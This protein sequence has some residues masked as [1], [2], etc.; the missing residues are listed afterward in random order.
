LKN[1]LY[2]LYIYK[3]S[4]ED[5]TTTAAKPE[6]YTGNNVLGGAKRKNGHKSM[7]GC[8]ICENIKNKAKRGGYK[9]EARSKIAG[10]SKKKNGHSDTCTCP[11]CKNMKNAKKNKR[12]GY[13]NDNPPDGSDSDGDTDDEDSDSD[14]DTDAEIDDV[15]AQEN[16]QS[17]PINRGGRKSRKSRKGNGHK[18]GC[19]CPICKNM[20]KKS[21]RGGMDSADMAEKEARRTIGGRKT[22]KV[23]RKTT[24]RPKKRTHKRR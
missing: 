16:Q 9:K 18:P 17:A 23:K 13:N 20:R 3:M 12:G 6:E 10:A 14:G 19:M 24:R 11:I 1:N 21:R 15:N 5:T 7:C 8:H 22:R 4:D 2:A